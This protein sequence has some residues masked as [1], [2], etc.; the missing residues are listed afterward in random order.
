MNRNWLIGCGAALVLSF[1]LFAGLG[2]V[3]VGGVFALTRPVVDASEEFLSLLGQG[4]IRDAYASAADG[5]RARQDE[6]SFT[7]AVKQLGLTEYSSATW[8]SRQI[9]NQ[10]GTAE[11]TVVTKG[12]GT[13]SVSIRLVREHGKWAVVAVSYGGIDV[14]TINPAPVPPTDAELEGMTSEALL[15][16]NRAVRAKDFAPF[17]GKLSD[18]WK[19]QTTPERLRQAFRVFIDKDID[20]GGISHAKP[21]FSRADV[22]DKGLLVIE[23]EYPT[24]PSRV[25]FEMTYA[26]ESGWK[27]AGLSVRVAPETPRGSD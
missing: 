3:F 2:V 17:Y 14:A 15:E 20:V 25:R 1:G 16:F 4:K 8:H 12:G 21:R 7:A 6:R 10:D 13:K 22:N 5:L 24:R 18:V 11:G 23:G 27:L 9:E 19:K 26:R